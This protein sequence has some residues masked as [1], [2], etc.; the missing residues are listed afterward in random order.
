MLSGS[1]QN[2]SNP[3]SV[4]LFQDGLTD[5]NRVVLMHYYYPLNITG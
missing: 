4:P 5:T 3:H 1:L 2:I